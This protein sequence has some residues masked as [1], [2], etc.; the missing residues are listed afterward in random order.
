MIG[1][2]NISDSC[3]DNIYNYTDNNTNNNDGDCCYNVGSYYS[4]DNEGF[5][6]G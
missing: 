4:G 3:N 6:I 5:M 1:S 2:D